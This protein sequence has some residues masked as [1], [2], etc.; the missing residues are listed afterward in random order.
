MRI[1]VLGTGRMGA[2]RA[3]WLEREADL[4][5][6]VGSGDP[7]RGRPVEEVLAAS[8]DAVVISSATPDHPG[9]IAACAD[10]GLPMLCE[11]PIALTLRET[12]EAVERA[13][14]AGVLLQVSFQRRF[15][16]GF[17]EARRLVAEGALGTLYCVRL[18]SFDHEPSPERFIPGSGGIYRDLLIHDFDVARWLTGREAVEVFA[19]GAARRWER[20]ARHGDIDTAAA[21]VTLDD[22]MPVLVAGT[23]HDPRGY[24]VRAEVLGSEDSIAVGL[25][26]HTPLRSVEAA[27]SGPGERPYRGFL[28]R[29]AAAFDTEMRLWLEAVRGAR[30]N[31]CPGREALLALQI[32]AA[33]D[34]SR[35]ERRVV[36]VSGVSDDP[37]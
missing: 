22:E 28:D 25:D 23:R 35:A 19:T 30:A 7:A 2:F 31:P 12:R 3:G 29:F 21:L 27:A 17:A 33:C 34:R 36:R 37:A 32:A 8:V 11:K 10:R 26:E 6:L 1:G 15:D 13:E 24:D 4:E 20:F 14:R 9:Q 18:S 5:V 16:P